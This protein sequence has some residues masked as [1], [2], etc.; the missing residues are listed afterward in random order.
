MIHV[1]IYLE[2]V[3]EWALEPSRS[4]D[5]MRVS[6]GACAFTGDP[7]LLLV[8]TKDS[9]DKARQIG[10]LL[11]AAAER[12]DPTGLEII[13]HNAAP[14][15]DASADHASPSP[16]GVEASATGPGAP[17]GAESDIE[18]ARSRTYRRVV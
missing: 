2:D 4:G 7:G 3:P 1:R 12:L 8:V 13:R 6:L 5:E 16:G 11:L 9:A 10:A 18:F 17:G 14:E 15:A